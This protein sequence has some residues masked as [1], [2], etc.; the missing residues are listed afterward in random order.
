MGDQAQHEK[1]KE[2]EGYR[3]VT[4][5]VPAKVVINPEGK[6]VGAEWPDLEVVEA[7]CIAKEITQE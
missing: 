4:V 5:H 6:V 7:I 2:R 3:Y 1:A